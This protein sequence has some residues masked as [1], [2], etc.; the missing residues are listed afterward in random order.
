LEK[1]PNLHVAKRSSAKA[2][3][4]AAVVDGVAIFPE[5]SAEQRDRLLNQQRQQEEHPGIDR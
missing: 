5:L 1:A 3:K 4:A 2:L